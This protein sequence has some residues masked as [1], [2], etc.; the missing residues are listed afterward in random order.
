MDNL[1]NNLLG[2][3]VI[4]DGWRVG[5]GCGRGESGLCVVLCGTS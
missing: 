4:A 3:E 5:V 2:V 1:L